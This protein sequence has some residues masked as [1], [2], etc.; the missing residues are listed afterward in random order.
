M[1]S[2]SHDNKFIP[3]LDLEGS[4][5][6]F[7]NGCF[8]IIH[9]GHVDYLNRAKSL[10]DYL[11]VGLNSDASVKKLKG[12]QRPINDQESRKFVSRES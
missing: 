5:L 3:S 9:K 10:G 1:N 11:I 12:P 6:V 4:R 8:D 7:T 2:T